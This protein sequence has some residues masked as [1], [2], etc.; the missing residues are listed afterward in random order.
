MS[1]SFLTR[2]LRASAR[3]APGPSWASHRSQ[4]TARNA[5]VSFGLSGS[6]AP[7]PPASPDPESLPT[8]PPRSGGALPPGPIP[9]G[10]SSPGSAAAGASP[11][12]LSR[13]HGYGTCLP[14]THSPTSKDNRLPSFPS[15]WTVLFLS[16]EL[17]ITLVNFSVSLS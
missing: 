14:V 3:K 6:L 15:G 9:A 16:S 8:C 2:P 4:R 11:A 1:R 5:H 12:G 13:C 17:A 10:P 7:G